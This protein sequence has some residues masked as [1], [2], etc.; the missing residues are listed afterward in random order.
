MQ[1]KKISL[2]LKKLRRKTGGGPGAKSAD[3]TTKKLID[4]FHD[5]PFFSGIQGGFDSG[6]PLCFGKLVK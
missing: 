1:K 6:E 3:A 2:G 4:L 5:E